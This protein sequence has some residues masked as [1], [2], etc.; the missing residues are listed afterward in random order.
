MSGARQLLSLARHVFN[1]R[2]ESKSDTQC[3]AELSWQD[4][5]DLPSGLEL[6]WLGTSGFRL[7]YAN[8]QL[9]IDPYV[10]RVPLRALVSGRATP[11]RK[12]L[13]ERYV[14]A[15]DAVL[16]GHSHFDHVLDAPLIAARYGA[17]VYGSNSVANL[18]RLYG[19]NDSS[20][21]VEPYRIYEIGPFQVTFVPSAHSKLLLGLR[22][23]YD[24]DISCEHFDELAPSAFGCGQVWGIHV[25]VA[26]ITLYHQ[27]SADLIDDAVTH[28][29]VDIFLC[30]IAGRGFSRA[31]V[32][33]ILRKLQPRIIVPHHYD[34]FF[35]PLSAPMKFSPNVRLAGF[36]D[37]VH[38]ISAGFDLRCLVPLQSQRGAAHLDASHLRDYGGQL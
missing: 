27:G 25:R 33:R 31:Y 8:H 36:V 10:T 12:S 32:S 38:A 4:G 16:I 1:R 22:V 29:D 15:S 18:L 13:I 30:G 19:L 23:P 3:A 21:V 11:P 5:H 17:K 2:E 7:R 14:G 9:L 6:E 20:V 24:H 35:R 34:D 26:G 37:E 28:R